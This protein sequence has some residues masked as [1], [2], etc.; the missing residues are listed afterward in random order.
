[1]AVK[2]SVAGLGEDAGDAGD[3]DASGVP[4]GAAGDI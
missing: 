3:G 2:R 4:S 1:M